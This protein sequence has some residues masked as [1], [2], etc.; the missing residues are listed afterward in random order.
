MPFEL[1]ISSPLPTSLRSI[2]AERLELS[3]SCLNKPLTDDSVHAIRKRL[4]ELRSLLRLLRGPLP[5]LTRHREN[6]ALRDAAR[7]LSD[8]RDT[9]VLIEALTGLPKRPPPHTIRPPPPPHT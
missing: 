1:S 5:R 4:K 8:L 9:A 7:P 6:T 3:L 2:A